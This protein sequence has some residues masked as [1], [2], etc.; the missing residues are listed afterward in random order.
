M[1]YLLLEET[2][3][4]ATMAMN[5]LMAV[6]ILFSFLTEYELILWGAIIQIPFVATILITHFYS[7]FFTLSAVYIPLIASF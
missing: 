7:A 3:K 2:E 6:S 1:A 5:W 4:T